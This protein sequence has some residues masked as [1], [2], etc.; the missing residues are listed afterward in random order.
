M[1]SPTYQAPAASPR[2]YWPALLANNAIECSLLR[3]C[4]NAIWNGCKKQCS[5]TVHESVCVSY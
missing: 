5:P 1:L 2:Y 4:N 3:S